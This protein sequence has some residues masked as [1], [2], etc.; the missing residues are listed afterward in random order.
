MW[1][2]EIP[3]SLPP[4]SYIKYIPAHAGRGPERAREFMNLYAK[5]HNPSRISYETG[6][7]PN[8]AAA[9]PSLPLIIYSWGSRL[10]RR[11]P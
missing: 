9:T 6:G 8:A 5:L 11:R 2:M 1:C 4:V 10:S 3:V 7:R